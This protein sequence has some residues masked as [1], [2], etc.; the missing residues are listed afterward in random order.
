MV[1]KCL[2]R[3][4]LGGGCMCARSFRTPCGQLVVCVVIALLALQ[5]ENSRVELGVCTRMHSMCTMQV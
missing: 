3:V 5:A 1:V 4:V 2:L